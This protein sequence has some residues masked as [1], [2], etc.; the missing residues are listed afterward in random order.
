MRLKAWLTATEIPAPNDPTVCSYRS[1]TLLSL[2]M[3]NI[4]ALEAD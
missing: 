3:H 1:A 4:F 2:L